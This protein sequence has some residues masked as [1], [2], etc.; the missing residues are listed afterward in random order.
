MG[1]IFPKTESNAVNP[2]MDPKMDP[3]SDSELNMD[4][5]L[6]YPK[7]GPEIVSDPESNLDSELKFSSLQC[8]E[9]IVIVYE[10][11]FLGCL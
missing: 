4:S 10:I 5:N 2:V 3:L 9:I 11:S 6:V 7:M 8:H 1:F